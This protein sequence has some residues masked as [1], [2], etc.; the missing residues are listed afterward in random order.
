[1]ENEYTLPNFT[2][3]K[4]WA[5]EFKPVANRYDNTTEYDGC[6][7]A[8]NGMEYLEAKLAARN[9]KCWSVVAKRDGVVPPT[10]VILFGCH[11]HAQGYLIT[12][13]SYEGLVLEVPDQN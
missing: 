9:N 13:K 2:S 6:L 5:K 12:E 3:Y 4:E 10:W 11:D 8:R 1:M 7:Y